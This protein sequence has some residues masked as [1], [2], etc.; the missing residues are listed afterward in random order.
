VGEQ[1]DK[2]MV[3]RV[4]REGSVPVHWS[5]ILTVTL[6]LLLAGTAAWRFFY[7][8][9]SKVETV[10]VQDLQKL[11]ETFKRIESSA[12]II[13]IKHQRNY[14]DFLNVKSF[15]GSEVGPLNLAHPQQWQGPYFQDNPTV[16]GQLYQIVRTKNG[17][18]IT[19]G[20]GVKLSNGAI[21]GKDIVLDEN[22]NIQALMLDPKKLF[23]EGN[24]VAVPLPVSLSAFDE[25]RQENALSYDSVEG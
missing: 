6:L 3:K 19:P 4:W 25:L 20:D 7:A 12:N 22:A 23:S 5:V 2:F 21:I 13:G 10:I 16:Q 14:I 11:A 15:T 1:R 8:P 18:F 24:V 9:E 17:Y